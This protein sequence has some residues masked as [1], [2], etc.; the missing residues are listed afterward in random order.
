MKHQYFKQTKETKKNNNLMHSSYNVI[1]GVDYWC[2]PIEV[3]TKK[4]KK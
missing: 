3:S 1:T 2:E 4:R